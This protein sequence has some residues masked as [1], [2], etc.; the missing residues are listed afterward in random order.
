MVVGDATKWYMHGV[1]AYQI[2]RALHFRRP[3]IWPLAYQATPRFLR[4]PTPAYAFPLS[5]GIPERLF[6]APVEAVVH[7]R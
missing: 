4:P 7:S 1:A 5:P 3:I 2:L 6:M